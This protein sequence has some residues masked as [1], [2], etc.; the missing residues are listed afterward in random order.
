MNL[1]PHPKP[2]TLVIL[3]LLVV[4]LAVAAQHLFVR[5]SN[6]PP[7]PEI[8]A[9][10]GSAAQLSTCTF[11]TTVYDHTGRPLRGVRFYYR[12]H[13]G[14]VS[15]Q[16]IQ[17]G[18]FNVET[19]NRGVVRFSVVQGATITVSGQHI[20]FATPQ[21]VTVPAQSTYDLALLANLTAGQVGTSFS[22]GSL[23]FVGS[24][25]I[26]SQDNTN[27][28]FDD[29]TNIL[30]LGGA[31]R[32]AEISAPATPASGT[33]HLYAKSDGK[34]YRKDDAGVESEVG[35]GGVWGSITGTIGD[36][37]DL[38]SALSAKQNLDAELT[39]LAGLT[40]AADKLPY[41]TGSG[42]AALVDFTSFGRSLVDDV[43][44]SAARTTLG[45][46]IGADVQAFDATLSALAGLNSTAGILVQTGADAFTKR[47]LTGTANQIAIADGDGATGAPTFSLAGPHNFTTLTSG[48]LLTGN[49]TSAIAA[50]S[51]L[52][53][54]SNGRV[55]LTGYT[56]SYDQSAGVLSYANLLNLGTQ[57]VADAGN[58]RQLE[59]LHITGTMSG[60]NALSGSGSAYMFGINFEVTNSTSVGTSGATDPS[61]VR[62]IIGTATTT[63]SGSVRAAHFHGVGSGTA[64]GFV[65]ALNAQVTTV[66]TSTTPRAIQVTSSGVAN[67][68]TGIYFAQEVAFNLGI[69]LSASSYNTAPI[70]LP[71]SGYVT[72]LNQAGSGN[73]NL[74]R[75]ATI[76]SIHDLLE[77]GVN[78]FNNNANPQFTLGNPNGSADGWTLQ[79]VDTGGRFRLMYGGVEH[80]TLSTGG[81]LTATGTLTA[82]S[83]ATVLTDSAGKILS[84]ALN[85]VAIAQGGTGSTSASD[86]RTALGL[87]IGTNV[88]AFDAT[89]SA[90]AAYNTNGI[91]TQTAS[92]TFTGRTIT[93]TANQI[94]V[95]NGDGVSGNPTLSLPSAVTLATSLTVPSIFGG[96][97]AGDDLTINAT[98]NGSPSSAF[99]LLQTNGQALGLGT[100]SPLAQLHVLK[101]WN[102]SSATN[103][104]ATFDAYDDAARFTIR[105]ANGDAGS[106]TAVLS[107]EVIGNLNFRGHTGSG[108]TTGVATI[109]VIA[110]ENFT[111]APAWGTDLVIL[112]TANGTSGLVE[113]LRISQGGWLIAKELST[114]PTTT[115]LTAS[116]HFTVY[117]KNDKLVFAYNNGGTITFLSIPLDGSTTT[118]TH[119]TSAP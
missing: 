98:S 55:V 94:T 77:F 29:A 104:M 20:S 46:A 118:W 32:L 39:A 7:T 51:K 33:V 92:D 86:A 3:A 10:T 97:G 74:I 76:G 9:T 63:N 6:P 15:G 85:T 30:R 109:N 16:F 36:Q 37:T 96:T 61:R 71:Y 100:A 105:R 21:T 50:S 40:S 34:V 110:A 57:G 119:N 27:L 107:G 25:G 23:L 13:S 103:L 56:A 38:Q 31:I 114:D 47:T 111:T 42:T 79:K 52:S 87:A 117:R 19:D 99:L 28:F 26:V 18:E 89:L 69:D 12:V 59:G 112:T 44:A 93:G 2:R 24:G 45:L 68:L 88:Q 82:G 73:L 22:A 17:A 60:G 58:V 84:A 101:D 14:A 80:F 49:G 102:G 43:N 106:E 62:G 48:G 65:N 90:F 78:T 11:S 116:D 70:R 108:F 72:S 81:N 41:F 83:G 67:L 5:A 53:L 66:A 115:Q 91:L 64:T 1:K 8:A 75:A 113:R 95:S 54:D 4:A 35:G